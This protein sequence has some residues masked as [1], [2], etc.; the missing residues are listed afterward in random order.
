M[1][2]VLAERIN[3]RLI[4]SMTESG[5][6][7]RSESIS[8]AVR[9][10]AGRPHPQVHTVFFQLIRTVVYQS[11]HDDGRCETSHLGWMQSLSMFRKSLRA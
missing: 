7:T 5:E 6:H 3:L 8:L 1:R 9:S 4:N 10:N 2:L 11:C